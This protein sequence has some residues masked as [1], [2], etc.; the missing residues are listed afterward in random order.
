MPCGRVD[1][2]GNDTVKLFCPNCNDIFVPPS[3]RFQGVD[4]ASGRRH[5]K[6]LF[7]RSNVYYRRVFWHN[8]CAPLLPNLPRTLTCAVLE[9]AVCG[10]LSSV[11]QECLRK[12]RVAGLSLCQP[13]STWRPEAGCWLCIRSADLRFQ[14]E[15]E[16]KEWAENAVAAVATRDTRGIGY[17]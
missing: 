10:W 1:I 3:S 17:G 12:Q 4:G 13:Q 6:R 8:V 14:G 15:R 9:G 16:S 7:L 2:P 11:S 5:W